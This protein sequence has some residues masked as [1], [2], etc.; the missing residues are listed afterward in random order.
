MKRIYAYYSEKEY[1]LV[2]KASSET[3]FSP[4]AYVKYMS[5][6]SISERNSM[7]TIQALYNEM[8]QSLLD[9]KQG[10]TFIVSALISDWTTLDRST[11]MHL[12][13]RLKKIIDSNSKSES[14][15]K[16]EFVKKLPGKIN[17]YQRV[18]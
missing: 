3:G 7:K 6:L 8:D 13:K 2:L 11:K 18:S 12:S 16:Y 1:A 15:Y 14:K 17:Q 9:L 5:L 10:E 4:S